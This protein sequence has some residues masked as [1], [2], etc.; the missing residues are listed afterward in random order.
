MER[1]VCRGGAVISTFDATKVGQGR[2]ALR[3]RAIARTGDGPALNRI[4][5]ILARLCYPAGVSHELVLQP[6]TDPT[7]VYRYRD[8]LYAED[9]LIVGLVWLDLFTWLSRSPS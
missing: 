9:M 1:E 6:Q 5:S 7:Q 8:G 3:G 4:L 2:G